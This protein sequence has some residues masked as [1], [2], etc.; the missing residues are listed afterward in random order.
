M[1]SIMNYVINR[2]TLEDKETLSNYFFY[3]SIFYR[4]S[5]LWICILKKTGNLVTIH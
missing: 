1:N 2:A 4:F 5:D 3:N